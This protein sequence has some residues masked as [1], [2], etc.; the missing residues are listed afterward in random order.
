MSNNNRIK[1]ITT[2]TGAFNAAQLVAIVLFLMYNRGICYDVVRTNDY[3]TG[4]RVTRDDLEIIFHTGKY[5]IANSYVG[6][7]LGR[8]VTPD[9]TVYINRFIHRVHRDIVGPYLESRP[10]HDVTSGLEFTIS[11]VVKYMNISDT[12]S[13]EQD[14]NFHKSLSIL[15]DW[16]DIYML[17]IAREVI[18]PAEHIQ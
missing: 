7:A 17:T 10:E 16:L 13:D 5:V 18:R 8:D 12:E 2:N 6:L 9:D 15:H 3:D 1:L 14:I 11:D 4:C